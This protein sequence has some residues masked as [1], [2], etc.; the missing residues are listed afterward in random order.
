LKI[1]LNRSFGARISGE[2][3]QKYGNKGLPEDTIIINLEGTTGQALGA[4]L[5]NGIT[6]NVKGA[7]NDYIGALGGNTCLYGA[8]GGML[9][10]A[11]EVGERFAIRN[12]GVTAVVEGTGDHP[13]EYMTGGT[14]VILGK[15]GINFG[16]GMTGGKAFIYDIEGTFYNNVNHELVEVLRVNTDEWDTEMFELKALLKDYLEKTGSKKAEYILERFR[17]EI[18]KFWMVLPRGARATLE[19]GKKGE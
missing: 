2:I 13:C 11:G 4:F 14:V 16:A 6:I 19:A 18:D 7:G 1:Q 12:S 15:T 17:L 9:Y 8:T 5:S 10:I 3:A